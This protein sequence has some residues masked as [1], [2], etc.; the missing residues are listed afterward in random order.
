MN[1]NW[2]RLALSCLLMAGGIAP[3]VAQTKATLRIDAQTKHQHIT[4]FGGFVCSPQFTYNHM[5]DTEIRKVWGKGS[6]LGCNIMR[7]YIPIGDGTTSGNQRAWSQ[8]VATAKKAKQM[9]LIVFASPWGQPAQWK[10]NGTINAKNSDGTTGKL[11]RENWADYAKYLEDY[12]VYMRQ[13]GVELDAISIQNEP[14]WPASYAGCLWDAGEMAE[15]VKT[16]GRQISCKIMAPETLAVSDNYANALNRTDVIDNFDIYG[17]HQY[18]GIQSAYKNLGK[19]GKEV[20]MTEY[21]INWNEIENNT[22]N[23]DFNKDFFNFFSA[24]NTCMLGDFN[25]WVHYASKR[26]YAMLGDGQRG[27]TNGAITK[28]GYI[29]A[30]FSRFVT[31]S[32]RVDA[33]WSGNS[34]ESSAYI[35]VTGDSVMA[36]MAN[37]SNDAVALTVDLPFYTQGGELYTTSQTK[38]LAKTLVTPE[39]ETCRPEVTIAPR[40]VSTV[41]FVRSRDRQVSNMK[42]SV[43]RFDRINDM[44]TTKTTFGAAYRLS[45]STRTFDHSNP[46]ISSQTTTDRGWVALNDRYSELVLHVKSVSSTMNYSSAL[47]TLIYV[48]NQGEVATHNYGDIDLSRRENFDLVFDLSSNTLPDG[49]QGV[50]SITNNNWSSKLTINFG[51]VYFRNIGN[52]SAKL[53]GTYVADD[54]NVLEY[55]SDAACTSLDMTGVTGLPADLPWLNHSNKVVY[56]GAESTLDADNVIKSS[57]C[58]SLVLTADGG[59]FRPA[60]AFTAEATSLMVN[61]EGCR[62]LIL[63]FATTVPEGVTAYVMNDA[64]QT[65][66]SIATIPAHQPVLVEAQGEVVFHG[67]GEVSYAAN[68][69]TGVLRGIYVQTPLYAGDYILGQQDGQWGFVRQTSATT[70]LKAFDAYASLNATED[71]IPLTLELST[72]I[73][74]PSIATSSEGAQYYDVLGRP[75]TSEQA[76]IKGRLVIVRMANGAT[77]KMMVR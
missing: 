75:L 26:Y 72:G 70:T 11:K 27:S 6:T 74:A 3:A 18:G 48:N 7:I 53:T 16:Y 67:A 39:E 46:L 36:V 61:V 42:G 49:C 2:K 65:W 71:F 37:T 15:F 28:R 68:V 5:S 23:Y 35:S 4:G 32:T 29:M 51:D 33:N 43:T 52:Y 55:T 1:K 20:W 22:R 38:S 17:G 30:N 69:A 54:S 63:P 10:T 58:K 66:T 21:L 47:T 14:D 45:N 12:V 9:G 59:D 41:L 31:G 50:I 64:D 44:S 34:L 76:C 19:K 25:A 24:I 56:V 40:S 73:S 8:S 60:S 57:V 13:N 62:L 77:R